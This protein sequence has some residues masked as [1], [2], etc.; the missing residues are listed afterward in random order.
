[1]DGSFSS[2]ESG[3][4]CKIKNNIYSEGKIYAVPRQKLLDW[5]RERRG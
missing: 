4:V 2:G 3:G 1:M 5:R